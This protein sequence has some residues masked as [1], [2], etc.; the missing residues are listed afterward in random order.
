MSIQNQFLTRGQNPIVSLQDS[1]SVQLPAA[2]PSG[3]LVSRR[4]LT[5]LTSDVAAI[6]ATQFPAGT[7][8]ERVS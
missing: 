3:N 4:T 6:I 1:I 7:Y 2:S 8:L 5:G